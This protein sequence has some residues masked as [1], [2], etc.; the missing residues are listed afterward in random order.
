MP[1][2]LDRARIE[3]VLA[4]FAERLE[5]DWL[6]VGGALAALWLLPRRV[7]E[8]IDLVGLTG[9]PE[10]RLRVMEL[11]EAVGLPVEAVNSAADFFVHR[12]E[13]WREE[14]EVFRSGP[15]AR[16]YRPTPTLFLLLKIGR[17]SAQDL[18]DG[19]AMIEKAE[20]EGLHLDRERVLAALSALPASH[21]SAL[22]DRRH[23]LRRALIR[24]AT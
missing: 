5:G 21:D 6:L 14:I 24:P 23:M 15:K 16:I 9:T 20:V 4:A 1:L 11:A 22:K 2:E 18:T 17:L 19:L 8:D 10:E 12:I 3:G 13:G 7:T